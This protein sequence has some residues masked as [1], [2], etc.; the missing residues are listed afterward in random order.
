M[1]GDQVVAI[2][3]GEQRE[4]GIREGAETEFNLPEKGLTQDG[5]ANEKRQDTEEGTGKDRDC[6]LDGSQ[7]K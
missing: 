2:H 1:D 3:H 7:D 6:E 5:I 4:E